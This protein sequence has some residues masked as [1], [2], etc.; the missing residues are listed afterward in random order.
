[1]E[2]HGSLELWGGV[3][4][5]MNR[6]GDR[7][8]DQLARNGHR[9]RLGDFDLFKNLGLK[10]LRHGVLWEQVAP[11]SLESCDWAWSDASLGRM[12]ELGLTP[13][14]GLVHHGSGPRYTS[15]ADPAFPEVFARFAELVAT[16]FPWIEHY[17]PVNEPLT[18][19]RFSG[20]YGIWYPHA[21]DDLSFLRMLVNECRG[22]VLAMRAIRAVNPAARLIQT[23]D[24]GFAQCTPRLQYQ[25][26]FENERRWLTFDLL[27][28]RVRET[29]PLWKYM[30]KVA[31]LDPHE[32]HWF[33]ENPCPP[34][35]LGINHYVT[36]N[37]FLD[38]RIE[39]YPPALHGGNGRDRYVDVEAIRVAGVRSPARKEILEQTWERYRIPVAVT[40]AHLGATREEQL[41]WV[42]E[43]WREANA[44]LAEGVDIRAVT[45][46][47]LLGTYDWNRLCTVETG[48]YEP[49]VFDVR[50]A[51]PRPT[52]L[53]NY[54][55]Q[56]A[57][58]L[59]YEHPI[60]ERDGWWRREQR[61]FYPALPAENAP[62]SRASSAAVP[63]TA[64]PQPAKAS[65]PL[66]ILGKRGT[67]GHAFARICEERNIEAIAI[68][69]ERADLAVPE[70]IRSALSELK[71]WAVVNATGYV[72]VDDAETDRERCFREN[73]EG[74]VNTA[75]ACF[76]LGLPYL[77]FSSD[78]V[79]DGRS[80]NAYLE[81]HEPRPL[82][83]YGA[84]KLEAENKIRAAHPSALIIRT[85][86]FFGPWDRYNFVFLALQKLAAGQ[87]VHVPADL[88]ISPTYVPDLVHA[89]LDLLID[90]ESGIWH[91]TN[92]GTTTWEELAKSAARIAGLDAGLVESRPHGE[93]GLKAARPANSALDSERARL[94][95]GLEASLLRF[96][97]DLTL[98]YK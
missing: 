14:V 41:R 16:R 29:H 93:L 22:T 95:P 67:L 65:R 57:R 63:D 76:E 32:L 25:A 43:I 42:Q 37:R 19:A 58:K 2:S 38:D 39:L 15:L 85:S 49:G 46:W 86:S 51:T 23:E 4:C 82:N 10:A 91:L 53:A 59:Q 66:L 26:D 61:S 73:V 8:F 74:A 71:P 13:I 7:I 81:S 60:L 9:G 97:S 6:V 62:P 96:F 3:E 94:M 5:T 34:D 44:L 56:L 17:T 83:V 70:Q 36:S 90:Q 52:A 47:S 50:S 48:F 40:E 11:E 55:Q 84:S 89:C 69:R 54:V 79:F 68:S 31:G 64:H 72:R 21:R 18:T 92:L 87:I 30:T 75:Q 77:T 80:E 28:G 24:L 1:M 88:R 35:I 98:N 12:R 45:A 78:L 20:L 33:A 27:C